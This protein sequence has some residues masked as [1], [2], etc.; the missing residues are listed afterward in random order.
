MSIE[1]IG[2]VVVW[3]TLGLGLGLCLASVMVSVA[4][5]EKKLDRLTAERKPPET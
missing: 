3:V 2:I 4:R 5:I 1:L